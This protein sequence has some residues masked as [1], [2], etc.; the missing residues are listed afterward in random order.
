MRKLIILL[1]FIT[2]L[3]YSSPRISFSD[4]LK[5]TEQNPEIWQS[6]RNEAIRQNLP[7]NILTSARVMMDA[8][9]IEDGKIVYAV[10]T[11]FADIYSGA[12]TAYYEEISGYFDLSSSR[13]DYGNGRIVDNTGGM[14]EPVLT[15]RS[16][17]DAY[18]MI[19]EWTDDKVY[20]FNA[21]NGDLVDAN[22]IPTTAPQLQSPKNA[23]LHFSGR[24]LLVSDQISDVVQKFDTNGTY[25][26]V[27]CPV[28][29]PITTI[30]DN[31]RSVTYRINKNTLVTVGS[32]A[33]QNT[34][35]QFDSGGVHIGTFAS[36][37]I[38]SP[39]DVLIRST[40]ILIS[41]SGGTNRITRYDANGTFLSNFYTGSSFAFP[42]QLTRLPNGLIVAAAFSNPSGT[43]ILDSAGN[44]IKLLNV[45]TG[46]RG[47][48]LLGNGHY[49]VTNAAGVH[50]I[51]SANGSLVRTI[52]TATNFQ[53]VTP[54]N[55]GAL[56]SNGNNGSEIPQGYSLEQNYPNPFN[57]S[58]SIKY[59]IPVSGF[60]KITVYD[61]NGREI[62]LLV[63][64]EKSAG[65]HEVQF[66]ASGLST[67]TYFYKLETE[68]F[69]S[70]KKMVLVK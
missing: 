19:P 49:I 52:L 54:Y 46:C 66:E 35:Q 56:L 58:T 65:S 47:V 24:Y 23:L 4:L 67:G 12:S 11:N 15:P 28:G 17:N 57:P 60:V 68:G 22:F 41:N 51:D 30:V 69:T 13:I 42:E 37:G 50:E 53:Y 62:G 59:S 45:V 16:S 55:P 40:D 20:L 31:M 29:G 8:K 3:V 38:N 27:F 7:V 14:Y 21:Q 34:V 5:T 39:F 32:G 18:I 63:N 1:L 48:Y 2:G 33:N 26:G 25:I 61:I 9:G 6:A 43:A 70:Y 36:T 44:F 64:G 10:I